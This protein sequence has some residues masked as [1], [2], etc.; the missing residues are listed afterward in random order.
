VLVVA[1]VLSMLPM[2]LLANTY[3]PTSTAGAW[4]HHDFPGATWTAG[5]LRQPTSSTSRLVSR[6][7]GAA[8]GVQ[9]F[10][11]TISP[12]NFGF[13][14]GTVGNLVIDG[15]TRGPT[16]GTV[17]WQA[18]I[19]GT[20][21]S[22]GTYRA[23]FSS[24]QTEAAIT[25]IPQVITSNHY[26]QGDA[27]SI[28]ASY[29]NTGDN[30]PDNRFIHIEF[31]PDRALNATAS[32]GGLSAAMSG[33]PLAGTSI[34]TY[35]ITVGLGGTT[36][37]AGNWSVQPTLSPTLIAA[38]YE[39]YPT[40]PTINYYNNPANLT[41]GGGVNVST[42]IKYQITNAD[43][44]N[45]DALIA[46]TGIGLAYD[47]QPD[48]ILANVVN[49]QSGT[50]TASATARVN[51]D[52]GLIIVDAALDG[53]AN[54]VGHY[55]LTLTP[56]N[57]SEFSPALTAE[58]LTDLAED[59][60]SFNI[61][62]TG[63]IVPT[64]VARTTRWVIPYDGLALTTGRNRT[65]PLFTMSLEFVPR[66]VGREYN[67]TST[68]AFPPKNE[69]GITANGTLSIPA[70]ATEASYL[71]EVVNSTGSL[72][73]LY[74]LTAQ[75]NGARVGSAVY[76]ALAAGDNLVGRKFMEFIPIPTGTTFPAFDPDD[77]NI[78]IRHY[79]NVILNSSNVGGMTAN[80]EV[81]LSYMPGNLNL[82]TVTGSLA[83]FSQAGVYTINLRNANGG[84]NALVGNEPRVINI[85]NPNATE[86]R[87]FV[88]VFDY[89]G[90]D[91][92]GL[93]LYFDVTFVARDYQLN[94]A[95]TEQ[96]L[97]ATGAISIPSG[98]TE[99]TA[100]IRFANAGALV[101][102]NYRVSLLRGTNELDYTVIR[103]R[104]SSD[105]FDNRTF[106]VP[107]PAAGFLPFDADD[108]TIKIEHSPTVA[109]TSRD[110][111]GAPLPEAGMSATANAAISYMPGMPNLGT[112]TGTF[113]GTPEIGVY[114]IKV[115]AANGTITGTEERLFSIAS[116]EPT[117]RQFTMFFDYPELDI[118]TLGL[119]LQITFDP[120]ETPDE[121]TFNAPNLPNGITSAVG[122]AIIPVESDKEDATITADIRG[123]AT[124]SGVTVVEIKYGALELY[125]R[126]F[127]VTAGQP[128]GVDGLRRFSTTWR[129]PPTNFDPALFRLFVYFVPNPPNVTEEGLI[130]GGTVSVNDEIG[131]VTVNLSGRI[132]KAGFF[133]ISLIGDGFEHPEPKLERFGHGVRPNMSFN[134]D[135]EIYNLDMFAP[136]ILIEWLA[137]D[138]FF[139]DINFLSETVLFGSSFSWEF[140]CICDAACVRPS[141]C[142]EQ[143]VKREQLQYTFH[144]K[145]ANVR[146]TPPNA[147]GVIKWKGKWNTTLTGE[148]DISKNIRKGGF[149]GVRMVLPNGQF[150]FIDTVRIPAQENVKDV[151]KAAK[152]IYDF[153]TQTLQNPTGEVLNTIAS[154]LNVRIGN[155]RGLIHREILATEL[156]SPGEKVFFAHD[157]I[158]RGVGGT[159]RIA[160]VQ[161]TGFVMVNASGAIDEENG[162]FT[163]VRDLVREGKKDGATPFTTCICTPAQGVNC[164]ATAT[165]TCA[166]VELEKG[167]FGSKMAKFR[168]PNQPNAP[169]TAPM[170]VTP[171]RNGAPFFLSKTN[172]KQ[173]LILGERPLTVDDEIVRDTNGRIINELV[174]VPLTPNISLQALLDIVATANDSTSSNFV[175]NTDRLR[176]YRDDLLSNNLILEIR[177]FKLIKGTPVTSDLT[178]ADLASPLSAPGIVEIPLSRIEGN[179]GVTASL[180]ALAAAHTPIHRGSFIRA[181]NNLPTA[182]ISLRIVTTGG[183]ING[184]VRG[185]NVET[186]FTSL[187]AGVEAV[188]TGIS[189]A[190]TTVALR[191]PAGGTLSNDAFNAPMEIR[192]PVEAILVGGRPYTG[193]VVE[194]DNPVTDDVARVRFAIDEVPVDTGSAPVPDT[195]NSK[196]EELE[197]FGFGEEEEE[198]ETAEENETAD[199][200]ET[201][202]ETETAEENETTNETETTEETETTDE[203]DEE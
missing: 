49:N 148:V 153:R 129:V 47:W 87:D 41:N 62:P 85:S 103:A 196:N 36:D 18:S 117:T 173:A 92:V 170:A 113:S 58:A 141:I 38:G 178:S 109:I 6:Q 125:K 40:T 10:N 135:F 34:P 157:L 30:N 107:V 111:A 167:Q 69:H 72:P 123:T 185:T 78:D 146:P 176:S 8:G 189:G 51:A 177:T 86:N 188:V 70:G 190:T 84:A 100:T 127:A 166:E 9:P 74:E 88:M 159:F 169:K 4:A 118:T 11:Y 17:G 200:N 172:A 181:N 180:S 136:Q 45:Q 2:T 174:W 156:L 93:G 99:G 14:A 193:A 194:V 37:F 67:A 179:L 79:P 27:V 39:I 48:A 73:G 126:A 3:R 44:I 133:R 89:D 155:D 76:K 59:V 134:F 138:G 50:V 1:L 154:E 22:T 182:G 106:T 31:T 143:I 81:A 112:V 56:T 68:P 168:I 95:V 94:A 137:D 198:T 35:E 96:G 130:A 114:T 164:Q 23:W 152:F 24:T 104:E 116:L 25:G 98:A 29:L 121:H 102:G 145:E 52:A 77:W 122:T 15:W 149:I 160:P 187:P 32:G 158:P 33:K 13:P 140:D 186:W 42:A 101:P 105:I 161:P 203:T 66:A 43:G 150:R 75:R 132:T 128:V 7:A 64:A 28:L 97:A 202:D 83:G 165:A 57:L 191:V 53:T 20:A 60:R 195:A 139:Y 115:M 110:K 55:Y 184:D 163:S 16:G 71:V 175:P 63:N 197:F 183:V 54:A 5:G 90:L 82:G 144:A 91:L 12:A 108:W 46:A 171:G 80:A 21:P 199:E 26:T 142:G 61:N 147:R 120:R 119:Y 65:A 19:T 124:R 151:N 131:T 192:I 162:V 201:T